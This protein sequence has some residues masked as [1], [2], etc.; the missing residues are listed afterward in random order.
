MEY[1]RKMVLVPEDM[2]KS[3][4]IHPIK[5]S[6]AQQ[7]SAPDLPKS[8]QTPGNVSS[9]LDNDMYDILHSDAKDK[10]EK[11]KLF[12]QALQ[13]FLFFHDGNHESDDFK[14]ERKESPDDDSLDNGGDRPNG[15]TDTTHSEDKNGGGCDN[16]DCSEVFKETADA[17]LEYSTPNPEK[18]KSLLGLL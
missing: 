9:R 4:N 5:S 16:E 18:K 15:L 8:V 1:A 2:V 17:T 3:D 10:R 14:T 7:E 13:R 11:W 6:Q 12:S